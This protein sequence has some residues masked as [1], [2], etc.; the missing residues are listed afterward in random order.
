MA[1]TFWFAI[2]YEKLRQDFKKAAT[3]IGRNL[4]GEPGFQ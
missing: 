4:G 2:V 3:F 1:I